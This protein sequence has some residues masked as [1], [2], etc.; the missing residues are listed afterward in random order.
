MDAPRNILKQLR[1]LRGQSKEVNSIVAPYIRTGAWFAHPEAILLT[2]LAS[3]SMVERKSAVE[4]IIKLRG[5]GGTGDTKPRSRRTPFLKFEA[6]TL[7]GLIDWDKDSIHEPVF[8]CSLDLQ[9]ITA[10]IETPLMVD[11][12]PCH[13]QSTERVVKQVYS[14]LDTDSINHSFLP[15]IGY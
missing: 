8:T 6:V 4:K 12:Y 9:E 1:L 5:A 15:L 10:I 13:T 2:M 7:L 3:P 14:A 11:Y